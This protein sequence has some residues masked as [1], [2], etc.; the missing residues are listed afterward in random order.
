M[1]DGTSLCPV[2]VDARDRASG[3]ESPRCDRHPL[4]L[5]AEDHSDLTSGVCARHW[6]TAVGVVTW[7]TA[8]D[9]ERREPFCPMCAWDVQFEAMQMSTFSPP[10]V[11]ALATL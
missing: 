7:E 9:H 11:S 6:K 4:V 1:P 10:V 5:G 2:V 8:D 3:L